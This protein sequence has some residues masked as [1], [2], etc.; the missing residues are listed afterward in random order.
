MKW[1]L[2]LPINSILHTIQ[3]IVLNRLAII[4]VSPLLFAIRAARINLIRRVTTAGWYF[5]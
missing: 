2:D 1:K 3:M 5:C 4:D